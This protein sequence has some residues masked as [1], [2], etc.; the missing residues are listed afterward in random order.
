MCQ[1]TVC[2]LSFNLNHISMCGSGAIC[3]HECWWDLEVLDP[4]ELDLQAV[5][6]CEM[7][8]LRK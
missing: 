8:M 6:I 1:R 3:A 2:C 7:W 4:L 5:M